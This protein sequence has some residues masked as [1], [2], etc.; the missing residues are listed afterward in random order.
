MKVFLLDLWYDLREKR[1]APVAVVLLAA[2][3]AVPLVVAKSSKNEQVAATTPATTPATV[4]P[5]I[6]SS[7][8]TGPVD[9]KLQTF[10]PRDPF[11]PTKVVSTATTTSS[12]TSTSTGTT[13]PSGTT[14]TPT[15][16][17]GGTTG[18]TPTTGTGTTGTT[19]P[20]T[21]T[22]LFT[23]T[24]DI[25][26]GAPGSE[27]LM[28]GVQRLELIPDQQNPQVVFLGVTTTG[29]TAVFLVDSSLGV[30]TNGKCKPSADQCSFLYL[31]PDGQ[32][33]QAELTDQNG[34]TFRLHLLKIHRI[35][36]TSS[37]GSGGGT[38]NS[39]TGSSNRSPA[40]TGSADRSNQ[41]ND[42][43]T[44][45]S[46]PGEPSQPFTFQGFFGDEGQ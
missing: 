11:E 14:T 44:S 35:T 17:G 46:P 41:S 42:T 27:K 13:G 30:D 24:V 15:E 34:N 16:T 23:Y 5:V 10:S 39:K 26:F 28:K 19:T 2:I 25:R 45:D 33:D 12:S 20:Q 9:S 29:K 6:Q 7:P 43:A 3:I 1:L 36:I 22:V 4:T 37:T 21:K 31:R 40:F 18:T 32:H 38:G 8:Q